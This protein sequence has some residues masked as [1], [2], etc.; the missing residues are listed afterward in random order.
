MNGFIWKEIQSKR[1]RVIEQYKDELH[2]PLSNFG[3]KKKKYSAFGAF[4]ELYLYAFVIGLHENKRFDIKGSGVKTGHFN[5]ISEWTKDKRDILLKFLMVLLSMDNIREEIKFD[6]P[7]LEMEDLDEGE[8]KK[9]I[10]NLVNIF[11][12][13]ANGGLE[14]LHKKYNNSPDD[15]EHFS[16]LKLIFDETLKE[17]KI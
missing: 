1:P 16:S 2:G 5:A 12:Q 11:E 10:S 8:L 6:F 13:F 14:I 4:Y 15:F 7:S 9:R 17:S 3:L